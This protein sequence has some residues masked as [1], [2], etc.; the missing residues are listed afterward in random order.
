MK[1]LV[2]HQPNFLPYSGFFE[3]I[4]QAHVYIAYDNVQ[5]TE[6]EYQNRNFIKSQ[7]GRTHLTL[8]VIKKGRL[9]QLINEVEIADENWSAKVKNR[10][11]AFYSKAPFYHETMEALEPAFSNNSMR[12]VDINLE[13]LDIV[14]SRLDFRQE[15][16]LSSEIQI[17]YTDRVDRI[18]KLMHEVN[19][20]VL[21]VGEGGASYLDENE[22]KRRGYRLEVHRHSPTGYPQQ[23]EGFIPFLSIIDYLMNMGWKYWID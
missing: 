19:A 7:N 16:L 4:N 18:F 20:K 1:K 15:M 17:D 13:L 3:Q 8:P 21:I 9:G 12:M 6:N 22:F 23:Y 5:F 2:I 11:N 14:L 10:L